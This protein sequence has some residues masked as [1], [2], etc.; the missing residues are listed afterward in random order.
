M[1]RY[2]V[3]DK[4]RVLSVEEMKRNGA[5]EDEGY[6]LDMDEFD[7]AFVEAMREWCGKIATIKTVD[8]DNFSFKEDPSYWRFQDWMVTPVEDWTVE[9]VETRTVDSASIQKAA[10]PEVTS[11][12]IYIIQEA[13]CCEVFQVALTPEQEQFAQWCCRHSIDFGN[14]TISRIAAKFE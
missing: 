7:M 3:G 12:K 9:P 10:S 11:K 6:D 8:R 4:V 2:K 13:N 5:V 1:T 14:V